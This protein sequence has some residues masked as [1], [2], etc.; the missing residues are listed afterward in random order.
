VSDVSFPHVKTNRDV[1]KQETQL[2][3]PYHV[4]LMENLAKCKKYNK[5]AYIVRG[6]I[7]EPNKKN[8]ITM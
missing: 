7:K 8:S 5:V 6:E 2:P 1:K 3:I 4:R